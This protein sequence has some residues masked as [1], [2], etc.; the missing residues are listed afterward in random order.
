MLNLPVADTVSI[1]TVVIVYT[2]YYMYFAFRALDPSN[3]HLKTQ[4]S[5]NL[6]TMSLWSQKHSELGDS[7]SVVLAIQTL[8][9]SI[10]VAIFV[11]GAALQS[12]ISHLD[13]EY[14]S[15]SNSVSDNENDTILYNQ[16]LVRNLIISVLLIISFLNWALVIRYNNHAGYV[17]GSME[18]SLR[19]T[20][21]EDNTASRTKASDL[22]ACNS[23]VTLHGIVPSDDVSDDAQNTAVPESS[24]LEEPEV[25]T[26]LKRTLRLITWHFNWGFRFI[27]F[28][29]PF[30][31]YGGELGYIGTFISITWV[32][33]FQRLSH[34]MMAEHYNPTP[35][36]Y[37]T[38]LPTV[39][40]YPPT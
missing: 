26:G 3:D 20:V 28:S 33:T 17:I 34:N 21:N 15:R 30:F 11:G 24:L 8:R 38:S 5:R 36:T 1:I 18:I 25:V 7:S 13:V 37:L 4:L 22:E 40:S 6:D 16:L 35:P 27:F 10:V 9:N 23:S 2:V 19:R 12:A 32:P 29:I 31:F 14:N 39:R